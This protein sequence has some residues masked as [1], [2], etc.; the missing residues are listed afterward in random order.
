MAH[1]F[2]PQTWFCNLSHPSNSPLLDSHTKFIHLNNS[3]AYL[4]E[5]IGAIGGGMKKSIANDITLASF[6]DIIGSFE[7]HTTNHFQKEKLALRQLLLG[8]SELYW[9]FL[10]SYIFDYIALGFPL[11]SMLNKSETR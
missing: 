8:N 7:L 5:I 10:N 3:K 11:P 2:Y 6:A 4:T 9:L 1:H